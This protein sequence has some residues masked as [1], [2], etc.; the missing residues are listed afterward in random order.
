MQIATSFSLDSGNSRSPSLAQEQ[1]YFLPKLTESE[2]ALASEKE[3]KFVRDFLKAAEDEMIDQDVE[4]PQ[5]ILSQNF[6]Y[7]ESLM[8]YLNIN[9]DFIKV[10]GEKVFVLTI[11][12]F[13]LHFDVL[14]L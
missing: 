11:G 2:L 8:K 5:N 7:H 4:R 10:F 3:E 14:K 9:L 13:K 12:K 1:T 6:L